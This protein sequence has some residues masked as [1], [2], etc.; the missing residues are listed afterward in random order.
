[1]FSDS[2]LR[3]WAGKL[4]R[5]PLFPVALF[6]FD[7]VWW[8]RARTRGSFSQHGEDIIVSRWFKQRGIRLGTYVDIGGSHPFRIS[9]TYL[10]Y[11]SGWRGFVFEPIPRLLKQHRLWRSRDSQRGIAIGAVEGKLTFYEMAPSVLSTLSP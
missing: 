7:I 3:Y 4:R 11:L 8:I 6:V 10:L 9:N 2:L 5:T 1:M